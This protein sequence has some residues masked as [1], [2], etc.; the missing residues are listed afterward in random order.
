[1]ESIVLIAIAVAVYLFVF[2]LILAQR[3]KNLEGKINKLSEIKTSASNEK[4]TDQPQTEVAG[5]NREF[6]DRPQV[7]QVIPRK[8][9][10]NIKAGEDYRESALWLWLKQ[11]TLVK[12]GAFLLILALAWFV[13]YAF[14]NNWIGEVGQITLGVIVGSAILAFGTLRMQKLANQGAIFTVLGST[15]IIMTISA[16]QYI[17][18]MFPPKVALAIIFLVSVYIAFVSL[19]YR[20]SQLAYA[21]LV[22]ALL[23]PMLINSHTGDALMFMLYLLLVVVG[24]L[25]VVWRLRAEKITLVALIGVVA[26]TM[27]ANDMDTAVSLLFSFVFTGIF[28][29][30]NIISLI[31]RQT[32][33]VSPV[34]IV[35][36]LITGVYLISSIL[37]SAPEEWVSSYLVI[38]A[39][40]F[41]YGSYQ[42][43][44]RT[45]NKI[46]FYIYAG[47]SLIL[48]GAATAF[49][50][51]GAMLTIILTLEVLLSVILMSQLGVS[52]K[53]LNVATA[54]FIIPGLL[55]FEHIG[56]YAW[57]GYSGWYDDF[58]ALSIFTLGLVVA[59][60]IRK[61]TKSLSVVDITSVQKALYS[62]A[63]IYGGVILWL[64]LHVLY[65]EMIATMIAMI[66]YSII[67]LILYLDGKINDK[68]GIKLAGT[69]LLVMVILRLLIIDVWALETT[70]RIVTFLIIGLLFMSTAFLPK[71]KS[72]KA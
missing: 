67:G 52:I 69:V 11:D 21:G 46:P 26:Y 68:A 45:L 36:A 4:V 47:V 72:T 8:D 63:G 20:R 12:V 24:T 15:T 19:Q 27:I 37:A 10:Y 13:S 35:T 71:S 48:I 5:A 14:S 41:A 3:I 44:M 60:Y 33:Q 70:G 2:P 31:R 42:V 7:I 55:T 22:S 65:S 58:F 64:V 54:L 49:E 43:F 38:W 1:M 50:F 23:A 40:A 29:I 62:L 28:F 17:Y 56:S 53:S 6:I 59:G 30:T 16:A 32:R 57:R 9:V 61:F 18:E 34:H 66:I 51:E 25:W 39:L